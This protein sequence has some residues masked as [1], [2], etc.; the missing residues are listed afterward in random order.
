MVNVEKYE[1][2]FFQSDYDMETAVD[3]FKMGR[4][5]YCIFMCHLSLEK[6]LKGLF[7]KRTGEF[8]SKSHSLIYFVEKIGLE[9]SDSRYEFLFTLNKISIPTRYP[10]DLRKLFATYTEKRT[11]EILNQ[12][13][14]TQIWIK[15]Q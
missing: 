1:E 9:M 5:I 14:E 3:M 15:Q 2:W 10:E 8:P 11:E 12:A 7:I 6:A 4:F 13:K